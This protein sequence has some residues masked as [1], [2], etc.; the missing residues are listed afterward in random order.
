MCPKVFAA[1]PATPEHDQLDK[2]LKRRNIPTN[3]NVALFDPD[4]KR[5]VK[6]K[7]READKLENT[8]IRDLPRFK[9]RTDVYVPDPIDKNQEYF[10]ATLH[11]RV[12]GTVYN[13]QRWFGPQPELYIK[14]I[15]NTSVESLESE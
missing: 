2:P 14:G 6:I 15:P 9:L 13:L 1:S 5:L 10:L 3:A 4:N 8:T 7:K 11:L 12:L